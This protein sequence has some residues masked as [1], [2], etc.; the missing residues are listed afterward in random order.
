MS[1]L[2]FISEIAS[3][4]TVVL[5][6]GT[7][8]SLAAEVSQLLKQKQSIQVVE[9]SDANTQSFS[10]QDVNV[11]LHFAGFDAPSLAQ[12][13]YHTSTLHRILDFS[14]KTNAKFIMVLPETQSPEQQTAISLISQFGKN[15]SLHY[16]LLSIPQNIEERTAAVEII[17]SFIHGFTPKEIVKETA[18]EVKPPDIIFTHKPTNIVQND[19]HVRII[20]VSVL[21][22]CLAFLM[23]VGV[24]SSSL[25]CAF[26]GVINWQYGVVQNCSSVAKVSSQLLVTQLKIVNQQRLFATGNKAADSLQTISELQKAVSTHDWDS[27]G[28]LLPLVSEGLAYLQAELPQTPT[29]LFGLTNFQNIRESLGRL[30]IAWPALNRIAKSPHQTWL[31]LLQDAKEIRATGGFLEKFAL[32][33]MENGKV[34]DVQFY[35][36]E[37]SD[38]Q[39]RGQVDP[40]DDMIMATRQQN[41]Y[42]RDGNWDADFSKTAEKASWFVGK[43]I[44]RQVDGVVGLNTTWLQNI[45]EVLGESEL[46]F[47]PE[48]LEKIKSVSLVQKNKIWLAVLTGL[49][50]RQIFVHDLNINTEI[51]AAG[52]GGKTSENNCLAGTKCLS[53]SVYF[54]DSNVGINKVNPHIQLSYKLDAKISNNKIQYTYILTYAN[55]S[56]VGTG[57]VGDYVN[58]L[59]PILSPEIEIDSLHVDNTKDNP[60]S[61]KGVLFTVPMGQSRQVTIMAHR[62]LGTVPDTYYLTW[63]NQPGQQTVP[64]EIT[65][66]SQVASALQFRYNALLT[67]PYTVVTSLIPNGK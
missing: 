63:L 35:D 46:T 47:S 42:L 16:S 41:W 13:L 37:N 8:Q 20:L 55:Q 7:N 51:L 24:W 1:A 33:N 17:R 34:T 60:V 36:T 12:T 57:P 52:W 61:F 31:V 32:V 48:V 9:I 2:K 43:E 38:S 3:P 58:Y 53:D 6:S 26:R 49:N 65:V 67:K 10:N 50:D 18:P 5:I 44:G 28:E 39:L 21:M 29:S 27:V 11:I 23:E 40:P 59:R 54:V 45:A 66:T 30:Q 22:V 4:H 62:N 25:Y 15:F 64:L 19:N 14:L 56:N